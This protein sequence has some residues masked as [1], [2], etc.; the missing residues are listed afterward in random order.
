MLIAWDNIIDEN[1]ALYRNRT[2]VDC[3]DIG[4]VILQ[5]GYARLALQW[6]Q[7]SLLKV[8]PD[9]NPNMNMTQFH[10]NLDNMI[11]EAKRQVLRVMTPTKPFCVLYYKMY[12]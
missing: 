9:D 11:E 1:F 7:I 12:M 10:I 2:G 8:S 4:Q 3:Y 6:F 5:K